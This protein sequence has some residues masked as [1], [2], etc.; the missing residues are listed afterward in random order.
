MSTGDIHPL[1]EKKTLSLHSFPDI[2]MG[3]E[4]FFDFRVYEDL[5]G[6][7]GEGTEIWNW[8]SGASLQVSVSFIGQP[9]YLTDADN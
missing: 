7:T 6:I 5:L 3:M 8:K 1:A 9:P 4:T 2:L